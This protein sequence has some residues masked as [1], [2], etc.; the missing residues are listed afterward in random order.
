MQEAVSIHGG[1]DQ[2]ERN[3]AIRLYKEGKTT[4]VC[5]CVVYNCVV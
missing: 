5:I 1:K 2:A 3:E 4:I